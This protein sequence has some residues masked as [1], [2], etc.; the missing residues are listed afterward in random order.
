MWIIKPQQPDKCFSVL[1]VYIL[2]RHD[3]VFDAAAFRL[4]NQNI[5]LEQ[6]VS[7]LHEA[8]FLRPW[9]R[10]RCIRNMPTKTCNV[11]RIGS[12]TDTRVN[13]RRSHSDRRNAWHKL[14]GLAMHY[15]RHVKSFFTM[16]SI[17]KIVVKNRL[18]KM[19]FVILMA[20]IWRVI[21]AVQLINKQLDNDCH[22][23]IVMQSPPWQAQ[24]LTGELKVRCKNS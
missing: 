23:Y 19:R 8:I 20:D 12:Q 7:K 17:M 15:L 16:I 18:L 3:V 4:L 10:R 5:M 21:P 13:R 14:Q 11:L 1:H 9:K 22:D 24:Q 6:C 2:Q